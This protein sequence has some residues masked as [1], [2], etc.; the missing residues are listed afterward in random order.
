MTLLLYYKF[1]LWGQSQ[2]LL[3]EMD[4]IISGTQPC[5]CMASLKCKSDL[6]LTKGAVQIAQPKIES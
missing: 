4:F 2:V 3:L 6:T 1:P 5:F